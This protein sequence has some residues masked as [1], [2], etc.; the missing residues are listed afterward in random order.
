LDKWPIG[1][2]WK[3]L[4]ELEKSRRRVRTVIVK[5]VARTFWWHDDWDDRLLGTPYEDEIQAFQA[6]RQ[7]QE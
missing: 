2:L 7:E 4:V 6:L 5:P 1:E 3:P